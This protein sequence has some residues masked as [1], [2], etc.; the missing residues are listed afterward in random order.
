[1]PRQSPN[2][3][4]Q[5]A[6]ELA[7]YVDQMATELAEEL[8]AGGTAPF[9]AQLT[10]QQKLDFYTNQLFNPDGTVNHQGRAE[11]MQR[12]GP[13]AFA[14]V[15]KAVIHAHPTLMIPAPPPG[16]PIV[17]SPFPTASPA[18][19]RFPGIP[20]SYGMPRSTG[21]QIMSEQSNL[22]PPAGQGPLG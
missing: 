13:E 21:Q 7:D 12:L 4:D 11:Q 2:V 10:E 8:M 15:F 6:E 14:V 18:G 5:V 17:P 9:A 3:L 19:P 16:A 20:P 22:G 1:M